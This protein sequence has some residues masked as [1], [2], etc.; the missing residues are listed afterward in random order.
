[1]VPQP[2][3]PFGERKLKE[4]LGTMRSI[5]RTELT[6]AQ[7][8]NLPLYEEMI[9]A[10]VSEGSL[11]KED[12]VAFAVDRGNDAGESYRR[13]IMANCCPTLTTQNKYLLVATVSHIVEG[14]P[15]ESREIFRKL[16]NSERLALQG[17]PPELALE[18]SEAAAFKAAGNAYPVPL[19]IAVLHPMVAAIVDSISR[20]FDFVSWPSADVIGTLAPERIQ[21][22]GKALQAKPKAFPTKAFSLSIYI[23]IYI[24]GWG[25]SET[26]REIVSFR[27]CVRAAGC[28]VGDRIQMCLW[29]PSRFPFD[30]GRFFFLLLCTM[31]GFPLPSP[32]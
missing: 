18:L 32:K 8:I 16:T 23:Y 30:L 31:G 15:D 17:F 25:E 10:K 11:T 19:L 3:A 20:G 14:V 9:K 13:S 26:N 24:G 27:S 28:K 1:M 22:F 4:A 12:V 21:E 2:L 29:R 7:Q 5:S 6:P